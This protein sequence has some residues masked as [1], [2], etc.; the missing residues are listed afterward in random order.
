MQFG[1]DFSEIWFLH[2]KYYNNENAEQDI[3]FANPPD[4]DGLAQ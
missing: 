2:G 3:S 1:R 4:L